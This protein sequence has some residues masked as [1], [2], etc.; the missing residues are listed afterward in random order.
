MCSNRKSC[1]FGAKSKASSDSQEIKNC[2]TNTDCSDGEYCHQFHRLCLR[3]Q[4]PVTVAPVKTSAKKCAKNSNC[5]SREYCHEMWKICLPFVKE[6]RSLPTKRPTWYCESA[7]DCRVDQ[8]CHRRF[9]TCYSRPHVPA[10][11]RS[12][13]T[14]PKCALQSE[15][16]ARFYCHDHFRIC[17]PSPTSVELLEPSKIK[18][19][20]SSKECEN[21]LECHPFWK[22]C[23]KPAQ[24]I[25][26]TPDTTRRCRHDGDCAEKEFCHV[27]AGGAAQTMA[28]VARLRRSL[29]DSVCLPLGLKSSAKAAKRTMCKTD[30]ECGPNSCCLEKLGVC[31]AYK[32]RDEMC[33]DEEEVMSFAFQHS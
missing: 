19:C 20:A 27:M 12:T 11:R 23:F 7:N 16:G 29:S 6:Y 5:K 15:C 18:T 9:H 2:L 28:T 32:L 24:N 14:S 30:E 13:P 4:E 8:L 25:V 26:E 1:F 31:L 33:I 3:P 22:I 10:V 17:L 21:G